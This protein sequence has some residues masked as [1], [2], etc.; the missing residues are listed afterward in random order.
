VPTPIASESRRRSLLLRWLVEVV[1]AHPQ[2]R[3]EDRLLFEL[4]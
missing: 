3:L 2:Y 4:R 1:A